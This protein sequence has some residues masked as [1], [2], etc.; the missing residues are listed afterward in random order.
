[1][2]EVEKELFEM[3]SKVKFDSPDFDL[4]ILKQ[5]MSLVM[6]TPVSINLKWNKTEKINELVKSTGAAEKEW[7]TIVEKVDQIKIGFI[8]DG[9][10]KEF[11]FIL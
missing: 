2:T 4:K 5:Q 6:G 8:A 9:K 11:K 1:M 10:P 3:L 7:K